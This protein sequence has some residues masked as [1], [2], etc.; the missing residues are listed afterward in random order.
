M[1]Q[2]RNKK[3]A[4]KNNTIKDILFILFDFGFFVDVVIIVGVY[5]FDK[6]N[7]NIII[8]RNMLCLLN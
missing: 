4:N 3:T 7:K 5:K 1:K 6:K 8:N 2:K